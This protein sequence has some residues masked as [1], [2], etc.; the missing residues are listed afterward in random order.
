M[1]VAI[2][3]VQSDIVTKVE[4][5]KKMSRKGSLGGQTLWFLAGFALVEHKNRVVSPQRGDTN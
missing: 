2:V 5:R 4:R 3:A 1:D